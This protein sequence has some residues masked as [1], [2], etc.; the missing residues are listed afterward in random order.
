MP[1]WRERRRG[2]QD[3]RDGVVIPEYN[4]GDRTDKILIKNR[5][6]NDSVQLF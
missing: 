4:G 5:V 6:E 1:E 3:C 2:H